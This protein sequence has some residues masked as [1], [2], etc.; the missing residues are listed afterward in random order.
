MAGA[1]SWQTVDG[2]PR[3]LV[4][5]PPGG[6]D[7][8]GAILYV[9]GG[10][11]IVGSPLTHADISGALSGRTGMIVYSL[12]YRLAPEHRAPAPV[13]DGCRALSALV[14]DGNIGDVFLCG[15]SAGAAIALAIER[16]ADAALRER[17][18]GVGA[19]YGCY[20]LGD[21][22]SL[23]EFGARA[24]G[25]D[26]ACI[27][28]FWSLAHDEGAPSPYAVEALAHPAGAPVYLLAAGNDPLRDD[29]LALAAAYRRCGRPHHLDLVPCAS[30]GF[31]HAPDTSPAA[32]A[33]DR[34]G[35]WILSQCAS[36]PAPHRPV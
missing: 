27:A 7:P 25:T 23:R 9:H 24:D 17:I 20:G 10:G 14:Q 15:D 30:H 29:S 32:A 22:P 13:L 5:R 6:A 28:R 1:W 4:Q 11:W 2:G 35:A 18:L 3:L 26:A 34:I 21:T 31:L 16:R 33:I 12:D 8:A 19:F 36:P